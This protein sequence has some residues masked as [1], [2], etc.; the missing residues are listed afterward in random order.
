[1]LTLDYNKEMFNLKLFSSLGSVKFWSLFILLDVTSVLSFFEKYIFAD[2][3]FLKWLA[4]AMIVD[5]I[6]GVTKV[7]VTKGS[8]FVTSKGL[9]DTVGK[10]IQYGGFLVIT[11]V[12]THFEI[13][14]QADTTFIWLN[15]VAFE[16]LI[17]IECKSVYENIVKINPKLDFV[18][19]VIDKVRKLLKET[20]KNDNSNSA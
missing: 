6:T 18:T 11:H 13:G 9:R 14:G 4:I 19:V 17:L 15:K 8:K 7:W 10:V 5:L 1:M 20:G 2:I 12:V 3:G 16:F